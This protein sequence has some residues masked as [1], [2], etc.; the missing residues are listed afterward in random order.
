MGSKKELYYKYFEEK[1]LS[2]IYEIE[3]YR[4]KLIKNLIFSSLCFFIIAGFFAYLFIF[5]MLNDKFNPILFPIILF[6]MYVFFI[7]SII[8]FILV[9]KKYQDILSKQMPCLQAPRIKPSF[10]L[11]RARNSE[12]Y[13]V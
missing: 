3:K 9:G 7:K 11:P 10:P 1:I 12:E 6:L 13:T 2:N 5:V 4:L 8:N